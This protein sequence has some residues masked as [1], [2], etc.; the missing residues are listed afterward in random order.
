MA[1]G[2][3]PGRIILMLL[4]APVLATILGV[5]ARFI[6]MVGGTTVNT[7]RPLGNETIGGTYYSY[8]TQLIDILLRLL[9]NPV[10]DAIIVAI[11]VVVSVIRRG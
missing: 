3:P 8:T 4:F 11:G 10:F 9:S 7:I 5:M 1:R 6:W 2:A